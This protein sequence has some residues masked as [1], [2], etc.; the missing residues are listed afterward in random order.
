VSD[1][2]STGLALTGKHVR[3][4]AL[5]HRHV[6]GLVAASVGDTSLYQRSPVPQGEAEAV[7]YVDTAL[8]WRAAE[9][10]VPFATVRIDDAPLSAQRAAGILERWAWPMDHPRHGRHEPDACE[11]GYTWL[12]RTTIR[13]QP[14]PRRSC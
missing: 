6:P 9:T 4:E 1:M 11:I 5:E 3:L 12:G 13:R 14:T 8:A 2:G 10:A 7:K